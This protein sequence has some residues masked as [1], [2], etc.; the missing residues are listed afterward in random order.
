[1]TV[2]TPIG[3]AR[4]AQPD[5]G[6]C[7]IVTAD[8]GVPLVSGERVEYANLDY[9]ASAPCLTPVAEALA[10]ALPY[11]ASVHR[12]AGHHSRV[13]TEAYERARRSVARFLGVRSEPA[14]AVVF[15]RGTTDALN[16]LARAVPQD[17]TVVVF[18]SEHH[19]SLLP[20]EHP[21]S[22]AGSV[23][24]LPLPESPGAAVDTARAALAAAPRGPRLLCVTAASNV[25]GEIWPVEELVAAAHAEGARVV[26]DAAQYAPHLPFSLS[27]TGADYVALSAHKLYAPFGSGVL[28]G[29][30]DWLREAAPYLSGGGATRLVT[31]DDVVWNDLPARHEAG[32]PNVL[33]A[34]ALAAACDTLTPRVQELLHI[35][36]TSLV[37]RL[38]AGLAGIGG[39]HELSLWDE[40]HPRV[41][42]VSFVVDGIPADLLAAALSAEYGIGVR[43]GLFCAHPLTR[44]LLPAGHGQAVRASLGVGTT[45]EH[46]D[47]L[48]GA[49]ADLVEHGPRWE[50]ADADGRLVPV[51]DPR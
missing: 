24:R 38:R 45:R 17:C 42:I 2:V 8:E 43:D 20:W 22:R 35:R 46:V 3:S 15:V 34:V 40:D 44:H 29:R 4:S 7:T 37:E 18:E 30:A 41:G 21:A 51:P 33:G 5:L 32:S 13:S 27:A 11:Y 25:T 6:R 16:L 49:V 14:D 50:Y 48:V 36:E 9:A 10:A 31:E 1:M 19:A 26:V 12:G 39:V 23:V 28:A 47:R